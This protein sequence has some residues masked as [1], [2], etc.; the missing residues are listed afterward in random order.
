MSLSIF[1]VDGIYTKDI[2]NHRTKVF[3][4]RCGC[5]TKSH[6]EIEVGEYGYELDDSDKFVNFRFKDAYDT[7]DWEVNV[8]KGNYEFEIMVKDSEN[9]NAFIQALEFAVSVLKEA[10]DRAIFQK[11]ERAF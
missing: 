3:C 8:D 4:K 6:L 5:G 11:E 2:N 7:M 1:D 10:R 9:C